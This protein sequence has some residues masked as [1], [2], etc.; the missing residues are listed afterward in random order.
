MTPEKKSCMAPKKIPRTQECTEDGAQARNVEELN[1]KS[2]PAWQGYVIHAVE[3]SF[4]GHIGRITNARHAVEIFSVEEIGSHQRHK[5]DNKGNHSGFI[6][7]L[8][9]NYEKEL[10]IEN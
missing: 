7:L 1:E 10:R 6:L 2:F 4:G 9:R 8:V 5:A 3:H